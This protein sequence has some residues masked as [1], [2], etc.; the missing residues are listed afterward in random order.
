[1][2]KK[3]DKKKDKRQKKKE[4]KAEKKARKAAKAK[5]GKTKVARTSSTD[6]VTI[7]TGRGASPMEIG[8][9]LVTMFNRGQFKEVE[10]KHW[11]P[12]IESVEGFGVSQAWRGRKAVEAKNA[13]WSQ[14]HVM[15]G[16]SAEGP[17]VGATGFSV[18][19]RIDVETRST[20]QRETMEEIGVYTVENGRIV[21]EEFMYSASKPQG[22]GGGSAPTA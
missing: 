15:H 16:A 4:E 19:F 9:D 17:Y 12:D 11:S 22:N 3:K 13:W 6:P 7:R 10:E 5:T 1:M 18:K 14:D 21:R 8:A 20:G 2:G